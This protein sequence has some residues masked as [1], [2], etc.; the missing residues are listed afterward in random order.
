MKLGP[1]SPDFSSME[2]SSM[3]KRKFFDR[4]FLVL[5]VVTS[6]I[7]IVI[8]AV[9]LTS[10]VVN[11]LPT[12]GAHED[13]FESTSRWLIVQGENPGND[14]DSI[15]SGDVIQA[16]FEVENL[17][18]GG[19]GKSNDT[20][21]ERQ[22]RLIGICSFQVD[23]QNSDS[24]V[25]LVP[26]TGDRN[27]IAIAKQLGAFPNEDWAN[28]FLQTNS[29]EATFL[30]M[31]NP[32]S[33]FDLSKIK[34][35]GELLVDDK[36]AGEVR[37]DKGWSVVL[38]G[39]H[40]EGNFSNVKLIL[41]DESKA[42]FKSQMDEIGKV[43]YKKRAGE[44]MSLSSVLAHNLGA[45]VEFKPVKLRNYGSDEISTGDLKFVNS[46]LTGL[47]RRKKN[48]FAL[49]DAFDLAYCPIPEVNANTSSHIRHFLKETNKSKPEEVGIGPALIGT[50]W[51][52]AG[53]AL[54]ALPLGIGTAIFLEEF[55]PTNWFVRVIH[56]LIQLNITNLA[57]VPSIVYGILGLTAFAGMFG[58]FGIA[59]DPY[60]E[61]GADH[62]YQFLSEGNKSV[63]VSVG[64][65]QRRRAREL[66]MVRKQQKYI[67]RTSVQGI[68]IPLRINKSAS[69]K[70][71]NFRAELTSVEE[72][73]QNDDA[74]AAYEKSVEA[75]DG[76]IAQL[77]QPFD[78]ELLVEAAQKSEL[79]LRNLIGEI[80]KP[81]LVDSMEVFT[82]DF[83]PTK[84]N[85]LE[86]GQPLPTDEAEL[87][88]T[89]RSTAVGGPMSKKYWY[90]FQLPFGRSVLA[91]SLTLM[92]V[93]LPVIIIASQEALRAV[94][95]SLRECALGLGSTPWQV[96]RNVTLPA[97]IPSIMTGAILAM[98]RAIGE[99]A[100]I[101]VICGILFV[102][103]GPTHLMD[104]FSILPVQIYDMA[105]LPKDREAMINAHNVS[106]AG[107]VVLLVI[108]LSFNAVAITIRQWTQK[109]LS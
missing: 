108:L 99:A 42:G 46:K 69:K 21:F 9:L 36:F 53:C 81:T 6:L 35:D 61:V 31:E 60:V 3:G 43:R 84:L 40:G 12:F 94:P 44:F 59:K 27:V 34:A 50:L 15:D 54:F 78:E 98:S 51:V 8:L 70:H 28:D 93:I 7:S 11:S 83:E 4:G 1:K 86:Q 13:R 71:E 32:S 56:S 58:L 45:E 57:G 39:G 88:V 100:P 107:I 96:V 101:L 55:K 102:T 2:I 25:T 92:L 80:Q 33:E 97:A 103:T 79:A 20:K 19:L 48:G 87:A 76:V 95:S 104:V 66:D 23:S 82:A 29:Q 49:A 47:S 22:Q 72:A 63:L 37:A 77:E 38:V 91:A 73:L 18:R 64:A 109:P 105:Q 26:A 30:L 62:Y 24:L 52:C 90:Y 65:D 16:L 17:D 68:E 106:A 89:L 85:L 5:C 67:F 74:R 75:M 10:I 14:P 41:P